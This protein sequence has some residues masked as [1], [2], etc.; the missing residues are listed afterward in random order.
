MKDYKKSQIYKYTRC[1]FKPLK[2]ETFALYVLYQ[3]GKGRYLISLN[4]TLTKKEKYIFQQF[5]KK[6]GFSTLTILGHEKQDLL[7]SIRIKIDSICDNYYSETLEKPS[8]DYVKRKFEENSE[9][10][11]KKFDGI[12]SYYDEFLKYKEITTKETTVKAYRTLPKVINIFQNTFISKNKKYTYKD[13]DYSNINESF[14]N[15]LITYLFK[16][17]IPMKLTTSDRSKL[18]TYFS[19]EEVKFMTCIG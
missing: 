1:E 11:K 18:T 14:F 16:V 4:K 2:N 13:I 3:N 19:G 8:T 12:F 10:A 17:E 15:D 6:A 7:D 9:I 5:S